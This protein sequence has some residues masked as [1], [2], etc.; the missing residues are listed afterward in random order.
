MKKLAVAV[1]ASSL[2]APAVAFAQ[3]DEPQLPALEA[4]PAPPAA[5][6]AVTLSVP[7]CR[8]SEHAGFDEADAH[9][10]GQLVCLA[11]GRAGAAPGSHYRVQLGKLGTTI[12]LVVV[13]EGATIGS[14]AD[15]REMRLQGIEEVEIAAPRIAESIVHGT[16]LA[17]TQKVDNL[18]GGETR[19][20]KTAPGKVHFALGLVGLMPPL[21]QGA[22]PAPGVDL[23]LHYET[24]N[25][26]LELGGSFRAGGGAASNTAP[27]M[28]FAIFS[29]GTR[30]YL[31]DSD[32]SPY[33]GGGLSWGY[34]NLKIDG[35]TNS[36]DNSGLG[37]YLDA[38]VEVMRTHHSHLAFGVRLDLPFYAL[39]MSGDPTNFYGNANGTGGTNAPASPTYYYAPLSV[40]A[41]ITF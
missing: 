38:G 25:G 6:S 12:I 26:R 5:P 37:A 27:S 34:L 17:E 22:A 21:D 9:T 4:P 8:L 19:Q 3:D 28:S 41:R 18:V 11:I 15:S 33:L 13:Q 10:A 32:F 20:P 39:N 40:E 1:L 23:D 35:Q 31:N 30:Y 16:P 7:A 36:G 2:L 29:L 14:L 24:A